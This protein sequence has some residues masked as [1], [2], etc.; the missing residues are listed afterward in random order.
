MASHSVRHLKAILILQR[1]NKSVH[2]VD[3]A[4]MLRVKKPSVSR[5]IKQLREGGFL[6]TDEENRIF[7]TD[8]GRETAEQIYEKY[9]ILSAWLTAL[10]VD[11]DTAEKDACRMEHI[12]S[13]ET[14]ERLKI[15]AGI[16]NIERKY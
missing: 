5:A 2:A 3:I 4:R 7:L 10:G 16:E 11:I 14:L 1:K 9:R 6:T 12:V 8:T 15:A 13:P